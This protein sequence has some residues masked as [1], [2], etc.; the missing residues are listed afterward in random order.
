MG[1]GSPFVLSFTLVQTGHQMLRRGL[2][3]PTSEK[4]R[5]RHMTEGTE[6]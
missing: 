1:F 5:E 4:H 6:E 2:C 3:P